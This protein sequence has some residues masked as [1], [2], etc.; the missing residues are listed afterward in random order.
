PVMYCSRACQKKMPTPD[1]AS[2]RGK[3]APTGTPQYGLACGS[4]LAPRTGRVRHLRSRL[5]HS[6]LH[7]ALDLLRLA[8]EFLGLAFCP[9]LVVI[10]H[11]ADA[12]LD[13]TNRFVGQAFRFVFGAAHGKSPANGDTWTVST[14]GGLGSLRKSFNQFAWPKPNGESA[15][16]YRT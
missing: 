5:F 11:L 13:V 10:G 8:L 1:P 14:V 4:G 3:P 6:I 2:S 7:V 9:Q 12:L 16:E 15:G